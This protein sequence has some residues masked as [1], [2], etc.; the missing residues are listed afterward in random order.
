MRSMKIMTKIHEGFQLQVHNNGSTIM[1]TRST[2]SHKVRSRQST[3][4]L[5]IIVAINVV[6]RAHLYQTPHQHM[7][8]INAEKGRLKACTSSMTNIS[9]TSHSIQL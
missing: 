4:S 2:H 7:E 9:G 5:L 8:N 1:Y 3:E 6:Q